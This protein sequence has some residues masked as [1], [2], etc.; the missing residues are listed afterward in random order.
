MRTLLRFLI[1]NVFYVI[2]LILEL[3]CIALIVNFNNFQ[4]SIYFNSSN[5]FVGKLFEVENSITDYFALTKTNQQLVDAN[6]AL[7]EKVISLENQVKT[8]TQKDSIHYDLSSEY[9]NLISATVVNNTTDKVHN[10]LTINKGALDSIKPDMGVISDQGIV[11]ITTSVSD[12]Y[13]LV[14]SVL[15]PMIRVSAKLKKNGYAGYLVWEADDYRYAKL[16]DISDYV[17]IE[18]NDTIVTTGYSSGF[19]ENIP[20]GIVEQL[21]LPSGSP[22]Y[23]VRVKL[24]TDFKTLATVNVIRDR[25]QDEKAE[26][27]KKKVQQ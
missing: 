17:P 10:Y 27:E 12:H 21:D 11:G 26:L 19:P 1:N 6:S 8:L 3:V 18:I 5:A 16:E 15:N 25:H 7:W 14:I 2:F 4:K 22:Y 20:I 23:N 13:T 24:A 9:Y